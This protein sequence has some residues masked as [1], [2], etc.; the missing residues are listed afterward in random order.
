MH[1]LEILKTDFETNFKADLGK[2]QFY[3]IV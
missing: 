3:S 1:I 2:H